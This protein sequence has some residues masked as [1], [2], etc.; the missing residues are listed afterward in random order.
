M[1]EGENGVEGEDEGYW[2]REIRGMRHSGCDGREIGGGGVG[3]GERK[4]G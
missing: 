1:E 3:V 2:S 4:E